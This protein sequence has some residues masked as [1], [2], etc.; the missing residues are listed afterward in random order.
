MFSIYSRAKN[1]KI[2]I[3]DVSLQVQK[4]I[5]KKI[6]LIKSIYIKK[7]SFL[8]IKGGVTIEAT[9]SLTVFMFVV[10]FLA[11]YI[12]VV[13]KQLS[14]QIK[15]DR[16]AGKLA[17]QMFYLKQVNEIT[18]YSEKIKDYKDKYKD[19]YKEEIEE[20]KKI[21][22]ESSLIKDGYIDVIYTYDYKLPIWNKNIKITQRAKVKDWTG[23]NITKQKD[24]V[25][26]TKYGKVYHR[27]KECSHL[28]LYISK[29]KYGDVESSRNDY[30]EKYTSCEFCGNKKLSESAGV[31]ITTDGSRYHTDL[32]CSGITRNIIE[33]NIKEV[34]NRKPCSNCGGK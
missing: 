26:I 31:F 24:L 15:M 27:S 32:Q 21:L 1:K 10:T 17:K 2:K 11:G 34:G 9:L 3:D 8:K 13:D 25:Y 4:Q 19:K 30:G 23:N 33:I 20:V 12:T 18:D 14:T 5:L 28:I 29:I 7:A 6:P 16:L 22:P